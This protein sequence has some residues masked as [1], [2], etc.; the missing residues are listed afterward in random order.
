MAYSEDFRKKVL[1][2]M[3]IESLTAYQASQRFK[4]DLKTVKSWQVSI[5][6]KEHSNRFRKLS[7]EALRADVEKYPDGGIN[8]SEQRGWA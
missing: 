5:D 6:R 8:M 3:S 4:I 1:E 2:I 7:L